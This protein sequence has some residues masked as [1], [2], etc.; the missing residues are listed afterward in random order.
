M[1]GCKKCV[2]V[3]I[4]VPVSVFHGCL[5]LTNTTQAAQRR[6]SLRGECLLDFC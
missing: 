2:D 6:S 1:G 3:L 4:Q 5:S